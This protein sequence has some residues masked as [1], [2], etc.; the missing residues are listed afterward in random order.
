MDDLLGVHVFKG[1]EDAGCKEAGLFLSEPMLPTDMV[2][3]IPARHE[4]HDQ[5][6]RIPILEG[7]PHIDDELVLEHSK[8]LSLVADRLVAFFGEN[9]I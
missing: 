9:P 4:I 1:D 2:P 6:E 5:I 3:E 7:L 8:Q